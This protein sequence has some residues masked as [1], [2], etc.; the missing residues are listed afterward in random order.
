MLSSNALV[1]M[2]NQRLPTCA[3]GTAIPPEVRTNVDAYLGDRRGELNHWFFVLRTV[4]ALGLAGYLFVTAFVEGSAFAPY[5]EVLLGYVALNGIVRLFSPRCPICVTWIYASID[6]GFILL[7]RHVYTLELFA[8]PN[9]TLVGILALVLISYTLFAAPTLSIT[10]AITSVIGAGGAIYFDP[11]PTETIGLLNHAS[12]PFRTFVLVQYL[13]IA[14]LISCMVTLRLHR[15]IVGHSVEFYRHMQAQL[16][17]AA[18]RARREQVEDLNHLKHNF[19]KVLSHELRNPIMPLCTALDVVQEE[20]EQGRLDIEMVEMARESAGTLQRLVGDYVQLADLL[21]LRDPNAPTWNVALRDFVDTLLCETEHTRYHIQIDEGL[22]TACDPFMLR[23]ALTAIFRRAEL[24]TPAD[25]HIH[26][27]AGEEQ[28]R[29]VLSV[30]DPQSHIPVDDTR[31][32]DDV[33][34]PST[35]RVFYSANTG[36]ELILAQHAL[37]HINGRIHI[38]SAPSEGTTVSCVLMTAREELSDFS[39]QTLKSI[40]A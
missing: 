13:S 1:R 31:S 4:F 35:E 25:A 40:S 2:L 17:S 24:C 23:G 27:M 26:V 3:A 28:D 7:L 11:L 15:Q 36:L 9:A 38:D 39:A 22:R 18:E 19:I 21:T 10:M 30:Y 33:F 12:H 20:M 37:R 14:C 5:L 6:V 32:L 16:D 29:V 8:D 34:A